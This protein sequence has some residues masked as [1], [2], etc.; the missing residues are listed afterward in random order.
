MDNLDALSKIEDHKK[1]RAL[2]ISSYAQ[3]NNMKDVEKLLFQ[4]A[5][6][7]DRYKPQLDHP[8]SIEYAKHLL[9][10]HRDNM[11]P[12]DHHKSQKFLKSLNAGTN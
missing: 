7:H 8:Q 2:R 5:Y 12:E 11:S 6:M 10:E 3:E 1:K 9:D 4:N